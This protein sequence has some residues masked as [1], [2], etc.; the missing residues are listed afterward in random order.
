MKIRHALTVG[1]SSVALAVSMSASA[2]T[3]SPKENFTPEQTKAIQKIIHNY[4]V[5]NPEVLLEASIALRKQ[6]AEKQKESALMAIKA[7]KKA[8]FDNKENPV[9][10]NKNG[11][12]IMAEFFDY[13][14][15]HCKEMN[16][17]VQQTIKQNKDLKVIFKEW[18]I[19]GGASKYAAMAAIASMKQGKYYAFHD[20]LLA[21]N[22]PLTKD[23]V[24]QVAKSVGLDVKKLK[25]DMDSPAIK[26]QLRAN[27]K[28][29]QA[30]KLQGTPAFVI[31]NKAGTKFKFIPG[32][33]S[34]QGLQQSL[35]QV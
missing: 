29:A 18:P 21:A 24:M 16:K 9:A 3:N 11:S 4:L 7:N 8:L 13:Q 32:A 34:K 17:V 14:C 5:N 15:G 22:N 2:A 25:K 12:I 27:F 19:F 6:M 33:I 30:L 35:G 1:L 20:A 28:L 10:G 23:K 26:Q 31:S